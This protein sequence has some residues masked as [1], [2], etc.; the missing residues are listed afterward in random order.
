MVVKPDSE[1]GRNTHRAKPV[2]AILSFELLGAINHGVR[3]LQPSEGHG[4]TDLDIGDQGI[5]ADTATAAAGI[6]VEEGV[7]SARRAV[8]KEGRAGWSPDE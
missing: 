3:D 6:T 2:G 8:G 1:P 4:R 7:R 5:L